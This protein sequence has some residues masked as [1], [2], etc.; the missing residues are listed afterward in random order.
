M[1]RRDHPDLSLSHQCRLLSLSRSSVYHTLQGESAQ[2]LDLMR[3]I[4]ELFLKY[5]F[6]RQPPDGPPSVAGG[7]PCRPPPGSSP[8]AGDG[9]TGH[10]PGAPDHHTASP[11][12]GVSL[13]SQGACHRAAQSGLDRGHRAPRGVLEPCGGERPPPSA[14]RSR[15]NEAEGSPTRG[16]SVK[17][18]SSPDNDGTRQHCQMAWARQARRKG[19]REEPAAESPS[20]AVHQLQPDR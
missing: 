2:N 19:V 8:D 15:L 17:G 13:S 9:A 4:D 20:R 1:I 6:Y 18:G 10:L 14:C 5:P 3:R 16:T 7:H 12:P 11:A